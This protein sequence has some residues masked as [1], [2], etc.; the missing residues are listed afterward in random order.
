M[1][2]GPPLQEKGRRPGIR[3]APGA[4]QA[5]P[6]GL[7]GG[8]RAVRP[9]HQP[10]GAIE[11]KTHETG[12][13]RLSRSTVIAT[14]VAAATAFTAARAVAG[15][16]GEKVCTQT[17]KVALKACGRDVKDNYLIAQAKCLN[18]TDANEMSSCLADAK[19]A[20]EDETS[21]CKDVRDARQQVCDTLTGGGGPYDP[22]IDPAN[23]VPADQIVGNEYFPLTPGTQWVYTNT[24]G[25][26]DTVTVT[27]QTEEIEGIP[28]RVVTDVVEVAGET[29]ENTED[30]YA[31]A[32]NGDV[33]YVGENTLATN[34]DNMLTSVEGQW[35][36]GVD[37]AKPGIIMPAVFNVGDVYR[38]EWLLGDAE[39]VAENLSKT[40]S[41]S[42]PAASCSG[43]CL[44]THEYSPLEPDQSE[45]KFYA[46]NV[47]VIVTLDDND[48]NFREELVQF[49]PAP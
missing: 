46:Q 25:E 41:E 1:P 28:V 14:L 23:F 37:G 17:T 16:K 22:S 18:I 47:G 7:D 3:I 32:L 13:A 30:W 2:F 10:T 36:T 40:A 8:A 43:N 48:P 33:W 38:Q 39:D 20:R 6:T 9:G 21:E 31:Q 12:R 29:T 11:M 19:S 24:D 26:T 42:T 15:G 34:P 27:D 49:T 44:K 45:S 5:L 35:E 4:G